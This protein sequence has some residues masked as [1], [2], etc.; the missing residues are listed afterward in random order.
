MAAAEAAPGGASAVHAT[1]MVVVHG[2]EAAVAEAMAT[3]V[4]QRQLPVR[5][6][7]AGTAALKK[8]GALAAPA[9]APAPAV[10]GASAADH[11]HF[12][13]SDTCWN[14]PLAA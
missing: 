7:G 10:G 13:G 11:Q 14:R 9:P 6:V 8:I 1:D 3:M 4:M 12:D 5:S 2:G